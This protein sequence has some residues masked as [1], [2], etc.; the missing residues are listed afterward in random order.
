[1]EHFRHRGDF[2]ASR[3]SEVFRQITPLT[4]SDLVQVSV[5]DMGFQ[6]LLAHIQKLREDLKLK[7]AQLRQPESDGT[8]QTTSP[9]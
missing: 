5:E 8:P 4:P 7:I 2:K 3:K 9:V 1:M 6:D